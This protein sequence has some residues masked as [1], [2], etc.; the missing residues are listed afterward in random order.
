MNGREAGATVPA[1]DTPQTDAARAL[2][3]DLKAD[4]LARRMTWD[5]YVAFLSGLGCQKRLNPSTIFK[6]VQGDTKR[7]HELTILDLRERL[8]QAKGMDAAAAA[9]Q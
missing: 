8:D 4:R 1:A 2:V 7:P 9:G 3:A 6:I 5:A